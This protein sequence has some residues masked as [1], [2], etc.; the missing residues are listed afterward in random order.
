MY[1]D[2]YETEM[3]E[4]DI[5]CGDREIANQVCVALNRK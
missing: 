5:V 3:Y 4:A 1:R 2:E